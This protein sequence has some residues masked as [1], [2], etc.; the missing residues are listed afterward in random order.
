MYNPYSKGRWYRFFIE[1]DGTDATLTT[2]D[3]I[4][5]IIAGNYLKLP[6]GYHIIDRI[7]DFN[8]TGATSITDVIK[9][10]S[11]GEESVPL[12]TASGYD[13]GYVYVFAHKKEA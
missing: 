8:F 10:Y 1:S 12:P 13:Y 11:S 5:T 7:Y 2:S 4:E 6:V 9:S 3:I